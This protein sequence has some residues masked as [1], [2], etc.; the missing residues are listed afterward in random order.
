MIARLDMIVSGL[1]GPETLMEQP[2]TIA[3]H[4]LKEEVPF[5]RQVLAGDLSGLFIARAGVSQKDQ[6][7]LSQI[8]ARL[9]GLSLADWKAIAEKAR[10]EGTPGNLI[11]AIGIHKSDLVKELCLTHCIVNELVIAETLARVLLETLI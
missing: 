4:V 8:N 10:Q 9:F 2:S 5:L 11:I 1:G 3:E 6:E 7:R